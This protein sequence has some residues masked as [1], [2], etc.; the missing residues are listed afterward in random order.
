MTA[1][2]LLNAA[3]AKQ[4]EQLIEHPTH[5][6]LIAGPAGSGKGTVAKWF[7]ANVLQLPDAALASYPYILTIEPEAGKAI[8]I[9]AVRQLEHFVSLKIPSK[10]NISRIVILYDAQV[11]TIEAQN[12]LLK[13]LEEPPED[14]MIIVTCA[15]QDAL[16]PTI[17]S[18]TQILEVARP[19]AAELVAALQERGLSKNES[20]TVMSLSGGLP[21]IA[22]ALADGDQDH[23]LVVA[24]QTARVLL[25]QST[26]DKLC[27]VDALAKNRE[28]SRNVIYILSQMAHAAVLTGKNSDRWQK[29]MQATYNAESALQKGGQPKLVLT[30]LMLNL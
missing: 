20:T 7:A 18:R 17:R 25:Q 2:L 12:A 27:Q 1:R 4:A 11:L 19:P 5:A 26:F 21:G 30:D 6:I 15:N 13:T 3:T 28:H 29:I 9:E 10:Q 8:G 23:P 24:A 22:F 14:T 16:L